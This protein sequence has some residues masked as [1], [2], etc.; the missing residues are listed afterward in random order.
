MVDAIFDQVRVRGILEV[1]QLKVRG[2]ATF[3][4]DVLIRGD[5][6]VEGNVILGNV[7][8]EDLTVLGNFIQT[9]VLQVQSFIVGDGL[10]D[11]MTINSGMLGDILWQV[12]AGGDI[13][14]LGTNRPGN[15]IVRTSLASGG[16][17]VPNWQVST[18]PNAMG[19]NSGGLPT[20]VVTWDGT[21]LETSV[22]LGKLFI[23]SEGGDSRF[24]INRV[25]N[26]LSTIELGPDDFVV[27]P[28]TDASVDMGGKVSPLSLLNFNRRWRRG[29]ASLGWTAGGGTNFDDGLI[30]KD[31]S[32]TLTL[33]TF[34]DDIILESAGSVV[35]DDVDLLWTM[36]GGGSIGNAG[37]N[38]PFRIRAS[39]EISAPILR[40]GANVLQAGAPQINL[41]GTATMSAATGLD[42]TTVAGDV[43]LTP[44]ADLV[45]NPTGVIDHSLAPSVNFTL[46]TLG[47]DPA[48]NAANLA[49][50]WYN[51]TD[52][53]V[54][55]VVDDGA[56]GFTVVILG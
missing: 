55:A 31:D 43:A 19:F 27:V 6:T 50:A 2:R 53:Q 9:D 22:D 42:L 23:V 25:V 34:D 12:D 41:V 47:A 13:G 17:A 11:S 26:G 18:P 56:G 36:D 49:R 1:W 14:A 21:K 4:R 40:F 51:S 29:F 45:L 37:D 8:V 52:R 24:A 39:D 44:A 7:V 5:L 38:R 48:A 16:G 46:E 20:A 3:D 10:A 15:V 33:R 35:V 28:E 54:K 32:G 30:D